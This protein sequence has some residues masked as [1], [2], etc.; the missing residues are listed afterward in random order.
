MARP[1]LRAADWTW[2][3]AGLPLQPQTDRR[4][5]VPPCL[6]DSIL[7]VS[8][9]S[10][11]VTPIPEA[12]REFSLGSAHDCQVLG[13]S[14]ASLDEALLKCSV[15]LRQAGGSPDGNADG[16][17]A[18]STDGGPVI[19]FLGCG[20]SAIQ[21]FLHSLAPVVG[22]RWQ[23]MAVHAAWHNSFQGHD[24]AWLA[25]QALEA[26]GKRVAQRWSELSYFGPC[27]RGTTGSVGWCSVFGGII[28]PGT[29]PTASDPVG[30]VLPLRADAPD[31]IR[32]LA[33]AGAVPQVGGRLGDLRRH[34][35]TNGR[36]LNFCARS[37]QSG[38]D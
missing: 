35:A 4:L 16:G 27:I 5:H 31:N 10:I 38:R 34:F 24:A 13:T 20:G 37:P 33:Q 3:F 18:D 22:N 19:V 17:P 7:E 29:H 28:H 1:C 21:T 25:S 12:V 8:A 32:I 30:C 23:F 15:I 9:A 14:R 36:R 2:P 11:L 6:R 26:C